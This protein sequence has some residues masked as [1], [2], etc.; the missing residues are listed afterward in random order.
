[1]SISETDHFFSQ[2]S[3][4]RNISRDDGIR[5]EL[6]PQQVRMAHEIA[7]AFDERHH[8]CI[9]APTGVGKTF[10]YLVPAIHYAFE[11]KMPVVISTHTINL[12]EQIL[13]K[14]LPLLKRLLD[15]DIAC[16]VG[17]GRSN[18]LCLR[19]LSK[20]ADLELELF[21]DPAVSGEINQL[22][23]WAERSDT[24]DYTQMDSP[25]SGALWQAVCCERGNCLNKQCPF[26]SRCFLFRARRKLAS[27]QIIVANHAFFFSS[28]AMR[29]AGDEPHN[30]LTLLPEFTA[31][32]LDEGHTIEDTAAAHLGAKAETF[33][34]KHLLNRLYMDDRRP[35]LLTGDVSLSARKAVNELRAQ[36]ELFFSRLLDWILAQTPKPVPLRYTVPNHI[37]NYLDP[38]INNLSNELERL[39]ES[40][41]ESPDIQQE[42]KAIRNELLEQNRN[43]NQFFAM[44]QKDCVYWF[45][46]QGK[47]GR[48]LSFQCVPVEIGA[49]LRQCLFQHKKQFPVVI[50]SATLAIA[51]DISFFQRRIGFED[52]KTVVLDTPFD[53]KKQVKLYIGESLP[54]PDAKNFLDEAEIH[55]RH[56]LTLTKGR[57]FVLF[58]SYSMMNELAERMTRFF[59]NG[60]FKVYVQGGK[61]R[62]RKMLELFRE[63]DR[64]V[65]FG[66]AS[67]WTGVDVSGEALSNVIICKLPFS[68][69]D[70]PLIEARGEMI[71]SR[72]GNSFREYSLPEAVLKFRQGFGRLIRTRDDKGIV[73]ILDSRIKQKF[74]G[75]FFLESI[76]ECPIEMF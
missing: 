17:K 57:A 33:I 31:V 38:G 32:V 1:M 55:L 28:L 4:L 56:F 61:Y 73:V 23:N 14:D 71:Q 12:Q 45:E 10:A 63:H 39:I 67:F 36:A 59:Q 51:G 15:R 11:M 8:L 52:A 48:E 65:I 7:S 35:R 64:A 18:Y 70:H 42:F 74:Y 27:S 69:P 50:T 13:N 58:T 22:L 40:S 72:G 6:R 24:G 46:R 41:D 29:E 20:I 9:E 19:R 68:V 16:A 25:V 66:T 54:T 47:E 62:P 53:F 43:L 60:G 21:S 44:E 30:S 3:P 49:R 37:S 76:P 2:Q 26:F 75:R 5:Y 34:L